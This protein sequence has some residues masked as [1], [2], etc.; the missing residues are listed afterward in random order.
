MTTSGT[1]KEIVFVIDDDVSVRRAVDNLLRS[2]GLDVRCFSSVEQFEKSDL[3]DVPACLVLDVRMPGMS[4]LDFQDKLARSRRQLPIIFITGNGDIPM[5]VKAMRGGAVEFLSK[6]F[7]DQA[8]LDAVRTALEQARAGQ[9]D[10]V[11]L[12]EIERRFATLTPR[13]REVMAHVVTGRLNKQIAGD[14]DVSEITI[15]VCRGQV[16][17]KMGATTFVEL[18]RMA[19]KLGISTAHI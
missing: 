4:G 1:I 8:L 2:V 14:L 17:R 12:S 19:D 16:M 5:T 9:V 18:L 15:K 10:S 3:P 11:L 13:E 6:P 7:R